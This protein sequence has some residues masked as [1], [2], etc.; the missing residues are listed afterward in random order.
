MWGTDI[1][2]ISWIFIAAAFICAVVGVLYGLRP[3]RK[4]ATF[5]NP[6]LL[7]DSGGF[8]VPK[9]SVIVYNTSDEEVL[10]QTVDAIMRQDYPDFELIVVC[11]ATASQ[12]D[13]LSELIATRHSSV[14]VTFIQPGS[15]NLSRRKLAVTIG[16]KAAKGDV[17]VTTAGNAVIPSDTWL[18]RM[19]SPFCGSAGN[20]MD[21]SL[22]VS[23]MDFKEMRGL[24]KWYRQFDSMLTDAL[25]VGSAAAGH[26][27][28]GDANNLAFRRKAFLDNKGYARTINLHN[29]DD[30][31]FVNEI[32]TGTNT[33]VTVSPD[34]VVTMQWGDSAGRVWPMTKERYSFTARW[35]PHAPF[36]CSSVFM[37]L[38]WVIPGFAVVAG[39]VGL[40]SLWPAVAAGVVLLAF[41]AVCIAAYRSLAARMGA[42]RLWWAVI[43]F[44]MWRPVADIIFRYEHRS[45]RKKNFTWQR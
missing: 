16:V 25:W 12:A 11:D 18:R 2:M 41:W 1:P 27:Y 5:S 42:V 35:L 33:R 19:M 20:G 34:S 9:A 4:A 28:R 39:V 10:L 40:P 17:V 30:D 36:V 6:D 32:A 21:L 13:Y 22:G 38:L 29:G 7:E 44:W 37:T 31:L 45:V 15:H 24:S 3:Y 8:S 43:P 23:R 14:Y 26:P